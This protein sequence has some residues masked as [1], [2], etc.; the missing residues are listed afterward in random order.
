MLP[1]YLQN[2]KPQA[3]PTTPLPPL[4]EGSCFRPD[5]G[6]VPMVTHSSNLFSRA[7]C[8]IIGYRYAIRITGAP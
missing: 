7:T 3:A 8:P 6:E 2:C 1:P 5:S 4:N